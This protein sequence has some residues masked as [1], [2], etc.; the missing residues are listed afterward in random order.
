M[1]TTTTLKYKCESCGEVWWEDG[2]PNVEDQDTDAD[3]GDV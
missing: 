2:L 3:A 1:T